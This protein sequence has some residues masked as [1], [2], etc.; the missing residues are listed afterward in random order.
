[1]LVRLLSSHPL[2]VEHDSK[3]LE[4]VKVVGSS[5]NHELLDLELETVV[6]HGNKDGFITPPRFQD[7]LLKLL[8]ISAD[9]ASLSDHIGELV[10]GLLLG[11]QVSPFEWEI[12]LE[13]F[14]AHEVVG[15]VVL[16]IHDLQLDVLPGCSLVGAELQCPSD[17]DL[18]VVEL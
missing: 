7:Q 3:S 8:D 14:P 16:L 6:E 1:V 11:V 2:L 5:A 15:D 10:L 17:V 18:M 13:E 9:G 12:L 4:V